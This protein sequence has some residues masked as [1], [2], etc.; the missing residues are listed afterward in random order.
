VTATQLTATLHKVSDSDEERLEAYRAKIKEAIEQISANEA[1]LT[2]K[3]FD[4]RGALIE[5]RERLQKLEADF[6]ELE[7]IKEQHLQNLA[8]VADANAEL[9][10]SLSALLDPMVELD[11]SHPLVQEW[12]QLRE[13]WRP[14]LPKDLE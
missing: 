8:D 1:E 10:K 3:G 6:A 11:S 12:K 7:R 14:H 4:A 9:F 5:L 2:A 13:Q